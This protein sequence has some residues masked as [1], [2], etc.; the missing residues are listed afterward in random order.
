MKKF[1]F[2]NGNIYIVAALVLLLLAVIIWAF[3]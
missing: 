1:L 3:G 2:T